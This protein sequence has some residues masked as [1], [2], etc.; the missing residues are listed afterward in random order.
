M[1]DNV[2]QIDGLV[3]HYGPVRALQGVDLSVHR[4]EVFG[5]L[6]GPPG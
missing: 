1:T 3:K 5:D 4:G 2:I 6:R